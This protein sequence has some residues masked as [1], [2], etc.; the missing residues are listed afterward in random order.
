MPQWPVISFLSFLSFLF[1]FKILVNNQ[2]IIRNCIEPDAEEKEQDVIPTQDL[3][4][5]KKL[6]LKML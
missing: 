5:I 2:A 3:D 1:L 6:Y 4:I